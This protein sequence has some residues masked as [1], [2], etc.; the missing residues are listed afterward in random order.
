MTRI[1]HIINPKT[2]D[3]EVKAAIKRGEAGPPYRPD[4]KRK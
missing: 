1:T 4:G 2:A 3:E